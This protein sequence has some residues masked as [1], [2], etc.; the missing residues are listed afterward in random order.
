[1]KGTF[2]AK[3]TKPANMLDACKA[4]EQEPAVAGK[5][6]EYSNASAFRSSVLNRLHKARLIE[7]DTDQDRARISPIGTKEVEEKLLDR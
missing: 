1:V 2:P 7:F 5:W 3:A 4:L 6:V